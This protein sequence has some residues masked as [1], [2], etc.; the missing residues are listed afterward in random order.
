MPANVFKIGQHQELEHH[1]NISNAKVRVIRDSIV[2]YPP[3]D[4]ST[5][6][7]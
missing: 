5:A 6:S 1:S 7:N 3:P 4:R 2:I